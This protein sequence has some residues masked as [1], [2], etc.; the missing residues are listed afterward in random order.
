MA[1]GGRQAAAS[2][3]GVFPGVQ[4]GQH[5]GAVSDSQIGAVCPQCGSAAAVHSIAELAALA[6][7]Q[8][9]QQP[10]PAAPQ[11][12]YAAE[13]QSGPLPGYAAEPRPGPL[14]GPGQRTGPAPGGWQGGGFRPTLSSGS[15]GRS[16]ED[17]IAGAALGAA[18]RFI[19]RAVSRKMEQ[20]VTE[21][22]LPAMAARL[23]ETL[24][25]QIAIAERYPELRACM[26]D[27]VIFL[28]GG[29]RVVSMAGM[30]GMK[31]TM[32]Q[33]DALV[34]SLREG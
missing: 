23:Q 14:P 15:A 11:Q 22:V 26:T 16:F 12:G 24:Q 6:R 19:G 1:D 3:R 31:L 7:A 28:A 25:T 33:A 9:G 8:L 32:E 2:S 27:D 17:D 29:S 13:P 20:T 34:A 21:K 4:P 30:T 18:A 5:N 10:G